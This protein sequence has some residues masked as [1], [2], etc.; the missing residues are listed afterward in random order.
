MD[1]W[2]QTLE[3]EKEFRIRET[4]EKNDE[5]SRVKSE[6][7]DVKA[8]FQR[9]KVKAHAAIQ[10]STS[11]GPDPRLAELELVNERLEKQIE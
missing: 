3:A 1:V 5:I 7:V 10:K 11:Q 4:E 2:S 9:Y 8:D 6:L